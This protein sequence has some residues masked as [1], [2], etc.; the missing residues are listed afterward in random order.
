MPTGD[1][2]LS[3][4]HKT[5]IACYRSRMP[6]NATWAYEQVYKA[7]GDKARVSASQLLTKPNIRDEIDRLDAEDL[8]DLGLTAASLLRGVV[9]NAFSDVRD[10]FDTDGS[11][12]PIH[13]LPDDIAAAI[14]GV[15]VVETMAPG[16]DG[17]PILQRTRKIRL[18]SKT[19]AQ[20]LL[21]QYLQLLVVKVEHSGVVTVQ[22]QRL[23]AATAREEALRHA[24]RNGT[25]A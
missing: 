23:T 21:A 3:D 2:G 7:R 18:W 6:R 1:R 12:R 19:D 13:A 8:R 16:P 5:F 4:N 15:D 22:E 24:H 11:L 14:S 20:K 25:T 10:L 9:R 17:E